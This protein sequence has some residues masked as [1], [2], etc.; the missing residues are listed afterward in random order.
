ML[1]YNQLETHGQKMT[2]GATAVSTSLAMNLKLSRLHFEK[3]EHEM[4]WKRARFLFASDT[5][6]IDHS[7]DC[8]PPLSRMVES[9]RLNQ[10]MHQG[11]RPEVAHTA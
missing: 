5:L 1:I 9:T 10:I 8:P 7:C 2:M 6:V 4:Q 11:S 3:F